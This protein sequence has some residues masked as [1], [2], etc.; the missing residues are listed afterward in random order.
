MTIFRNL[1]IWKKQG[2]NRSLQILTLRTKSELGYRKWER[3]IAGACGA[4]RD[5]RPWESLV[6]GGS[7]GSI[8]PVQ[9]QKR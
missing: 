5:K 6:S 4:Q 9:G 1:M 8:K 3:R 2:S 7:E